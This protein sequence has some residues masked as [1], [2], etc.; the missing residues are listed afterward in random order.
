MAIRRLRAGNRLEA[1]TVGYSWRLA[2]PSHEGAAKRKM[3][4]GP[5]AAE[6]EHVTREGIV[7]QHALDQHGKPVETFA[8]VDQVH[9][10]VDLHAS[11]KQRHGA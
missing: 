5:A 7:P 11:R 2:S 9:G 8:H 10:E 1:S 3:Q 6:Y 4:V